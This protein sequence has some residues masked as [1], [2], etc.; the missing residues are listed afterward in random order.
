MA[1]FIR[2]H[3]SLYKYTAQKEGLYK[4]TFRINDLFVN[5]LFRYID[6]VLSLETRWKTD[7]ERSMALFPVLTLF[8]LKVLLLL[9]IDG[10]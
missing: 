1:P 9:R 3:A 5:V 4:V 2:R 10:L 7:L 8:T 6:H